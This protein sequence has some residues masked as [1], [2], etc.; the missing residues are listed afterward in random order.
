MKKLI[1]ASAFLLSLSLISC[2]G[3]ESKNATT[4]AATGNSDK[5]AAVAINEADWELKDIST[6]DKDLTIPAFAVKLPKDAK[7]E[8]DTSSLTP[9]L[10]VTFKNKYELRIQYKEHFLAAQELAKAIEQNRATDLGTDTL[11]RKTKINLEDANGYIFTNQ[12]MDAGTGKTLGDPISHFSYFLKDK[13]D[14]YII[15]EDSRWPLSVENEGDLS[16]EANTKKIR[17]IIA[18]SASF[19]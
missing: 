5:P 10:L 1:Y 12:S 2:G 17:E 18:G 9:G 6:R 3:S 16:S 11:E 8:K 15:I 13:T 7:I 14:G 19:K 4:D